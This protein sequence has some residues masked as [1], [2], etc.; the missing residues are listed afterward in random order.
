VWLLL[1]LVMGIDWS[2]F[3]TEPHDLQ[4]GF[5]EDC[6]NPDIQYVFSFC[7]LQSGKSF[8]EADGAL[9]ALY[10]DRPLMLPEESLGRTPM[11]VWI[12]SKNYPLAE[13]MFETFRM[14]SPEE[15]WATDKQIRKWGVTRGDRFTH[16]LVPRTNCADP[17][18]IMLRVR[19]A[20]DPNSLRATNRLKLV[21]GDEWAHWKEMS[22]NNIQARAIVARTKFIGGTSP[23]GKNHA[24][25]NIAVPGGWKPGV[26]GRMA[27]RDPKIAVHA[28]TSA[29]NPKAD[30]DHIARL[31]KLFGREYA[32]QELMGM[33]TDA[34]G[35]VYGE[36]DRMTM[37]QGISAPSAEPEDYDLITGGIDPG[38]TD[39]YAACI[40]GRFIGDGRWYQLFELHETQ[41]TAMDIAPLLIKAQAQWKVETWW[42]DKRRPTD[43]SLL[44][45]AGVKA[46]PNIDIHGETDKRTIVPMLAVCQGLMQ[47]D[48]LR[49]LDSH[50]ATAEEFENYHYP[51][52]SDDNPKNT[53]DNPVDWM[54][55]HM[56]AM[57]YALCSVLELTHQAP[58]YR[59]GAS[60]QPVEVNTSKPKSA[61]P[62]FAEAMAFQDEKFD[63]REDARMSGGRKSAGHFF[64]QKMRT[65]KE[66]M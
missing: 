3:A 25:R 42:T 60:Q 29:D 55:H 34:I 45:R 4:K 64:R 43:I 53:N 66:L 28:W 50:E 59:Q 47:Q 11:E 14:R 37:M 10:G 63:K 56:D 57:R 49:I 65:R 26:K 33:F 51:D 6:A 16:W 46:K 21:V 24:Y 17:C 15:I 2:S 54:N 35:F 22:A 36:F 27:S 61:I 7:G 52:P 8:A 30:K 32:A 23:K 41:S 38:W 20:S 39:P 12:A 44:R 9:A 19:T 18:P 62:S 48:K 40:W 58:R 5:I 31:M 13:S 1:V